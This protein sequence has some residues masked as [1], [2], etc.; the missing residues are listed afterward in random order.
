VVVHDGALMQFFISGF[1]GQNNLGD[2][3]LM[4]ATMQG[5]RK[6]CSNATIVVRPTSL[7]RIQSDQSKSR[8]GRYLSTLSAY[9][10]HLKKCDWLVFGGGT[11]FHN[12][13]LPMLLTLSICVMA[14]LMGI[15]IAAIGVGV[16][17]LSSSIA[18]LALRGIIGMS[19][20][21]A[22]RDDRAFWQ[23]RKIKANAVLTSDLAFSL[24]DFL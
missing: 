22:V 13:T 16:S 5:I 19:D 17:D 2:D 18:R 4:R 23:C 21:F 6:I 11:V 14:R 3:L 20:L 12:A 10:R 1:Y 7:D 9:R 24:G 8:T 15:R